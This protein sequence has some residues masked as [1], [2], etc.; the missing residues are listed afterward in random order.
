MIGKAPIAEYILSVQETDELRETL[1][2]LC[3]DTDS[4]VDPAFYDRYWRCHTCLPE[5][6]HCF[7]ENFR[8]NEPAHAALIHGFPVDDG[9]AGPTPEHWDRPM[10]RAST[11]AGSD[12]YMALCALALG[13]PFAWATLQHGRMIQDVFPIRGDEKR[14]NGH[15]SDIFLVFHTDDAFHPD[16]CDYLLLFG[17][18]NHDSV[19]TRVASARDLCLDPGHQKLLSE[20]RFHIEPDE[21]HIRQLAAR[22]PGHPALQRAIR[23]RDEPRPVPVLYGAS[24]HPY[25]RYDRAYMHCVVDSGQTAGA[26][27]DVLDAELERVSSP[28]V[29]GQGTLLVL[30]NK[31]AAHARDAFTARYDGTDRWLRKII[32]KRDLRKWSDTI[33][34]PG[35]RLLL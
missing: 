11:T 4:P 31:V 21:E 12:R 15:G 16:T 29:I 25:L 14:Q 23:M 22:M 19:P 1:A 35:G 28:V 33:A 27:L 24:D 7:L 5:G 32:V 20:A 34:D 26:A 3:P 8:R 30:D 17:V 10:S 18:R 9:A 2:R 13:E 6:V